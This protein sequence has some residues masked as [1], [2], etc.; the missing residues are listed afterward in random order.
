MPFVLW[1]AI[2]ATVIGWVMWV[3]RPALWTWPV[4]ALLVAWPRNLSNILYGNSDIWVIAVIAAGT[5]L[6]WPAILVA[7]KPSVAPFMLIGA[8]HRSWW[9]AGAVL[10]LVSLP[11]LGLWLDYLRAIRNSDA[12]WWWS[13]EDIPPMLIPLVA[14]I[15]RRDGGVTHLSDL[16]RWRPRLAW[17][18]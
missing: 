9:I 8:R 12:T 2:P 6:A 13:I 10:A 1:Y 7:V 4:I 17:A 11:F 14:R 5:V 18:P 16:A 15:G 3:L